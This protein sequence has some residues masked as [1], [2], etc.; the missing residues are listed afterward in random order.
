RAVAEGLD[1]AD[2]GAVSSPTFTLIHE[3]AAWLPVYHFDAYR[4]AG[5]AAFAD[6]GVEEYFQGRGVCLVEWADRVA[7]CLPEE[8]LDLAGPPAGRAAARQAPP[9]PPPARPRRPLD[10]LRHAPEHR[11][12][13]ADVRAPQRVRHGHGAGQDHH[14]VQDVG[15]DEPQ[16]R[17]AGR[18]HARALR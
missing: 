18:V 6:L 16:A 9:R 7:A 13:R 8:R 11:H 15:L 4:L 10:R 14:R 17:P 5:P 3:Y 12:R 1:I 2:A